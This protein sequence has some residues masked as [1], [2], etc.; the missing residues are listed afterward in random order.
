MPTRD[1]STIDR[2]DGAGLLLGTGCDDL[3][4]ALVA[5]YGVEVG[6]EAWADTMVVA[7]ERRADL[8]HMENPLGYLFRVGQSKARPHVRW[9]KR[10]SSLPTGDHLGGGPDASMVELLDALAELRPVQRA[11]VLLVTA[12]G[13]SYRHA[14]D[15]LGVTET[16]ITKHLH[17]GLTCL[18]RV[19]DAG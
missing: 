5:C 9:Q 10:R 12:H 16:A 7:W 18:R 19:L 11:A 15:V 17:R 13:F 14:A 2:S 8:E 3:R 4:A 6:T 1:T